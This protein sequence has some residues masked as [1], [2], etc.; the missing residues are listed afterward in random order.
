MHVTEK[1]AAYNRSAS[2]LTHADLFGASLNGG[3]AALRTVAEEEEKNY[4]LPTKGEKCAVG[5]CG[6][7]IAVLFNFFYSPTFLFIHCKYVIRVQGLKMLPVR[8]VSLDFMAVV[9]TL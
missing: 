4:L 1:L 2:L 5:K 6:G 8:P 7:K 9:V 3:F